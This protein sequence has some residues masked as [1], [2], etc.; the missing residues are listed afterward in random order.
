MTEDQWWRTY[1]GDHVRVYGDMPGVVVDDSTLYWCG[2]ATRYLYVNFSTASGFT[3][4]QSFPAE[5][6]TWEGHP[7][8]KT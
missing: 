4:V 5:E 6:V 3:D 2:K 7:T 1:R 8:N